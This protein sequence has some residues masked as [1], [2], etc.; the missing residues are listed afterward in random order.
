MLVAG[1]LLG[2]RDFIYSTFQAIPTV[3]RLVQTVAL[4]LHTYLPEWK[5]ESAQGREVQSLLVLNVFPLPAAWKKSACRHGSPE[6]HKRFTIQFTTLTVFSQFSLNL[7]SNVPI[8]FEI[9][10]WAQC[11]KAQ[12]GQAYCSQISALRETWSSFKM[13]YSHEGKLFSWYCGIS[14]TLSLDLTQVR[15]SHCLVS[16]NRELRSRDRH[17]CSY[18]GLLQRWA[19]NPISR[20]STE[21]PYLMLIFRKHVRQYRIQMRPWPFVF[22][23]TYCKGC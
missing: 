19:P 5:K 11:H 3:N 16:Q 23:A 2:R 10:L 17:W 21:K 22:K 8:S 7:T 14:Y 18:Q 13:F 15:R 1:M 6:S 4:H 12:G 9:F 20:R